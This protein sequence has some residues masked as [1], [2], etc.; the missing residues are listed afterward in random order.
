MR[1]QVYY[2]TNMKQLLAVENVYKRLAK[3]DG[4]EFLLTKREQVNAKGRQSPKGR[5]SQS[6]FIPKNQFLDA[7]AKV[8]GKSYGKVPP[9]FLEKLFGGGFAP[10]RGDDAYRVYQRAQQQRFEAFLKYSGMLSDPRGQLARNKGQ[11]FAAYDNS[12]AVFA[13]DGQVGSALN[14]ILTEA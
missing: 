4:K 14:T 13:E 10:P 9:A 6:M 8:M 5:A 7:M 2:I 12:V 1:V 11:Y 3:Y